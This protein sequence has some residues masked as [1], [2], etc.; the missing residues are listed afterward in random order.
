MASWPGPAH[1]DMTSESLKTYC[2]MHPPFWIGYKNTALQDKVTYFR[3][4]KCRC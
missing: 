3:H 1:V 4:S 2:G